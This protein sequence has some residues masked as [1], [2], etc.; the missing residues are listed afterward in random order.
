MVEVTLVEESSV[1]EVDA[2]GGVGV[3]LVFR[4]TVEGGLDC[5]SARG[6]GNKS[7]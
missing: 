7:G 5:V 1:R 4:V 3:L 6:G 2:D